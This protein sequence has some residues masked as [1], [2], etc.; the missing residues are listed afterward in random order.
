MPAAA[1]PALAAPEYAEIKGFGSDIP[2]TMALHQIVPAGYS[3]SF[4]PGIDPGTSVSWQGDRPWNVVL[5]DSL[6]S[7]GLTAEIKDHAVNIQRAGGM[8]TGDQVRGAM[9][10]EG[11]W[12]GPIEQRYSAEQLAAIGMNSEN[13]PTN[14]KRHKPRG[15]DNSHK[16]A[17]TAPQSGNAQ[18]AMP[19][20]GPS[21]SPASVTVG[22]ASAQSGPT[23]IAD[24]MQQDNSMTPAAGAPPP[25]PAALDVNA[26]SSWKATKGQSLH[27][28]L[29][30]WCDRSNVELIWEAHQDYKINQKLSVNGTFPEA[31]MKLLTS[32]NKTTPR[33]VG[34]LHPN[35]PNGP[36]VLIIQNPAGV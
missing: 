26:V 29:K 36:S 25:P 5:N 35:L 17:E 4:A 32:Y 31:V 16:A 1:P 20:P 11:A 18:T 3:W 21:A 10:A 7:A 30:E 28:T 9:A 15:M 2:L 19:P 34:N 8:T 22:D 12:M 23:P 24:H 14:Y 27:D 13:N 6:Q 33:P